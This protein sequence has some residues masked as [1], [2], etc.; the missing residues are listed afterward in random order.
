[1]TNNLSPK[2]QQLEPA[3]VLIAD[4]ESLMRMQVS[5]VMKQAGY[6]IVETSN[7]E[8]C[9][10]TYVRMQPDIV[11]LDAIMPEM[12]GFECCMRLQ[13]LPENHHAPVLMITGLD[14]KKS[15]DLAFESGATDYITKPI[16]WPVLLHRV[17]RLIQQS[18]IY[19]RLEETNYT[20]ELHVQAR[21]QELEATLLRLQFEVE[22]RKKA[23]EQVRQSL[24]KEKELSDMKSRLINTL[25]HEFRTPLSLISLASEFLE[26]KPNLTE[27]EKRSRKFSQ[28]RANVKRI[29]RI[30]DDA[31]TINRSESG[32]ILFHTASVDFVSFCQR[33]VTEWQFLKEEKHELQFRAEEIPSAIPIDMGLLEQALTHL[34]VN[35]IRYSPE[36]GEVQIIVTAQPSFVSFQ[37]CD[38]G[39]GIPEEDRPKIFDKFYRASNANSIPGS[40]GAGLG[41]SIVKQVIDL[42]GGKIQVESE[43]DCGT[44]MTVILPR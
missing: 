4:D 32:N 20:L 26:M 40:P 17:R 10:L 43:I 24:T 18:Q 2:S 19:R 14:D 1:M 13:T 23:E 6:Q 5:R 12:D 37:I 25:S 44:K 39:I 9:L 15:V 7:G 42:H 31:L 8:E 38:R 33:L 22:E 29:T 35:A 16:H 30:L 28:I 27:P 41:L 34:F 36:G 3:L 11:L 21:T